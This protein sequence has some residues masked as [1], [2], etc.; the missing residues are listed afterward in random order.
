[1]NGSL[2][3]ETEQ[4]RWTLTL[5]QFGTV[6]G[7]KLQTWEQLEIKLI[8]K[9]MYFTFSVIWSFILRG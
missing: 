6:H 8:L 4:N 1:M 3:K 7:I 5:S 2:N 9:R